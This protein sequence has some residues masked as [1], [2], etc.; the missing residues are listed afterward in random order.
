MDRVRC[1]ALL[2][3]AALSAC[4]QLEDPQ[5]SPRLSKALITDAHL[6]RAATE[7]AQGELIVQGVDE[8]RAPGD[9]PSA[10]Y[11]LEKELS[12]QAGLPGAGGYLAYLRTVR[13][14]PTRSQIW[15]V[16]PRTDNRLLVYE[17]ARTLSSVA[18]TGTGDTLFFTAQAA[19]GSSNLD[20][21]RLTRG[22]GR[23]T[24]LT[25][26]TTAESDVSVAAGGQTV[27]WSGVH[28]KTGK[29]AVY[30]RDYSGTGFSQRVLAG[31][32]PYLEPSVSGDGAYVAFVRAAK[33]AQVVRFRK[34]SNSYLTIA[35]PPSGVHVRSPSVSNGG[36]KVAW[37]EDQKSSAS[38][39]VRVKTLADGRVVSA[40]VSSSRI[41]QPQLTSDG[42]F[43]S[44]SVL[45]HGTL[46]VSSKSLSSGQIARLTGD[47][48]VGV[49]NTEAFWQQ[50]PGRT[51]LTISGT[52]RAA[53]TAPADPR[54]FNSEMRAEERAGTAPFVPGEVI[55]QFKPG[56]RAQAGA[57]R[58]G[59]AGLEPVR[60]L[61]LNETGLYRLSP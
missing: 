18:V 7:E 61:G 37:G 38:S 12:G 17:G 19:A 21:Y 22:D 9:V 33:S 3:L 31:S 26:T 13:G 28:A 23:V 53:A 44:Y 35:T 46:N 1:W 40:G 43:L 15:L 29:R 57:D 8:S 47:T 24:R 52:V 59:T 4:N 11:L 41:L 54:G 58:L 55:V 6:D 14:S 30:L 45:H 16:N 25:T 51:G 36:L 56:L 2:T 42:A 49:T 39:T 5:G 32:T 10:A 20:V 27:V 48:S 60:K 50:G 34:G